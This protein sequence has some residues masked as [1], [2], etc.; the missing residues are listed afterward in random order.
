M[1]LNLDSIAGDRSK[2][3]KAG[4]SLPNY[5]ISEI[6]SNS[7]ENP[8]WIHFGAGNIFRG[9]IAGLA[10]TLIGEGKLSTGVIAS[11][12][13]DGE[14]IDKIYYPF[15]FLSL[16]VGLRSD[17]KSD[18][19]VTAGIVDAIKTDADGMIKLR[20]IVQKPSLQMISFTITEKGYAFS[21]IE[22]NIPVLVKSD[23]KAGPE[24]PV[25]AI[26]V[27]TA[28]LFERYTSCA[29]PIA[30][31]SMDNCSQNGK[32]LRDAVLF[33]A[34]HWKKEGFVPKTFIDYISNEEVVSFPWSMIDKITPRPSETI[35]KELKALGVE[36]MDP[37]IT[38]KKT[39]IAPFVNAEIPQYLVIE[40]R[41]PNGRPALE[42]AGVYMTDRDTV[43]KAEKMKV[44]TCLNPL[45]TALAVCGCLLGY[46]KISDEMNDEDL[47][48]LVYALG[49]EG[50]KVVT[51]PGIIS[52][53]SFIKEVLEERLPNP[54]LPDT[55]QRIATD[56][57]QKIAIRFGETINGYVSA[58]N[59]D[60]MKYIPFVLAAWL[61]Y[62]IGIDDNGNEMELSP[63]PMIDVLRQAIGDVR[64]G[65]KIDDM[66]GIAWILTKDEIF[67][68]NILRIKS[69]SDKIKLHLNNMLQGPGAVRA[70][71]KKV[72]NI[73]E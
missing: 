51:S 69:L 33:M 35:A 54:Y 31:V 20:K 19:R 48:K 62:L 36:E 15:D 59:V 61:R 11:D 28:L 7:A 43:N 49:D 25:T 38:D 37:I 60:D 70:E 14:I 17:G 12:T 10:D 66:T 16:S 21:D 22:G 46:T 50:M 67:G 29:A 2:W 32:K 30:L 45:H 44:M 27:V 18:K 24:K 40:D 55:P 52:P 68:S 42:D 39:F 47:K 57:S 71:L 53:E 63:D 64:F 73:G 72:T 65:K 13:F 23:I 34:N 9:F 5:D 26:G 56:T 58:G 8:Q 3:K 4:I 6:R 41:F 1:K